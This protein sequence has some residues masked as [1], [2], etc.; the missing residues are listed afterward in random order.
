MIEKTDNAS[1]IGFC[2]RARKR[3][4]FPSFDDE[5][6]TRPI[7]FTVQHKSGNMRTPVRDEDH[8][9]YIIVRMLLNQEKF[10]QM[11]LLYLIW[12]MSKSNF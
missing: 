2:N 8:P 12:D 10:R 3:A 6:H 1:K 4:I 9:A 5:I 7:Y 11:V